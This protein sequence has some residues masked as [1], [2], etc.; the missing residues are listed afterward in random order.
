M[1]LLGINSCTKKSEV[2][3][4]DTETKSVLAE[5]VWQ[6]DRD[7]SEKL[8]A[9]IDGLCKK[10][11]IAS[12]VFGGVVVVSGPGS[13]VAVRIGVVIANCLAQNLSIPLFN[14]T[15]FQF[16]DFATENKAKKIILEA[17]GKDIYIFDT[18][19]LQVE[20]QLKP[21]AV[22]SSFDL[23]STYIE[24]TDFQVNSLSKISLSSVIVN[25]IKV[26]KLDILRVEKLPLMPNYV[27]EPAIT[28]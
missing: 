1:I 18:V 21:E 16:L 8:L 9:S 13:F 24:I 19:S 12:S 11:G 3:L 4:I 23:S 26:N 27:K 28:M 22:E 6:S 20:M 5:V 14:L 25:L 10:A 15:T 7:E 2:C 17:G